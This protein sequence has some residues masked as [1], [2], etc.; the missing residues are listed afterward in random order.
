[1]HDAE[2][3]DDAHLAVLLQVDDPV[4]LRVCVRQRSANPS[5][6]KWGRSWE[7]TGQQR[8]TAVSSSAKITSMAEGSHAAAGSRLHEPDPTP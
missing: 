8:R 4:A 2:A 7:K 5:S 6:S 3:R 1:M